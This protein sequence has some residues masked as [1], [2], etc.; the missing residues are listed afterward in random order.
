MNATLKLMTRGNR[1][2]IISPMGEGRFSVWVGYD[3]GV[4]REDVPARW[5]DG[6]RTC[7]RTFGGEGAAVKAAEK[8]LGH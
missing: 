4:N 2:A 7:S 1:K 5:F 3:G 6:Y 8:F